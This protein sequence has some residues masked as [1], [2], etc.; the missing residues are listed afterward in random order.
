MH[1]GTNYREEPWGRSIATLQRGAQMKATY[2]AGYAFQRFPLEM[3]ESDNGKKKKKRIPKA[4]LSPVGQAP[5]VT[6]AGSVQ[7]RRSSCGRGSGTLCSLLSP[8]GLASG[9]AHARS[10]RPTPR[11]S[12]RSGPA[13][14]RSAA[15]ASVSTAGRV[16]SAA[17]RSPAAPH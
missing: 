6:P 4:V 9:R 14:Q 7:Q 3:P 12:P 8:P 11:L 13:A 5:T 15:S 2:F 16:G 1:P 17:R 10:L